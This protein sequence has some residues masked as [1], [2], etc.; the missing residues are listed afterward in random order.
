M[1]TR[2][3]CAD[4][5]FFIRK[6]SEAGSSAVACRDHRLL[7]GVLR[8]SHGCAIVDQ[9]AGARGGNWL[10]WAGDDPLLIV[11]AGLQVR[12]GAVRYEPLSWPP[13]SLTVAYLHITA[14]KDNQTEK[15]GATDC[16][17]ACGRLK[18]WSESSRYQSAEELSC[19][20]P[21]R[22]LSTDKEECSCESRT[23]AHQ[24]TGRQTTSSRYSY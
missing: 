15:K 5:S 20:V 4:S 13:L 23:P 12:V 18:S 16:M 21:K 9:D 2:A 17:R 1:F 11:T 7:D 19:Q 3:S 6:M 14:R 24:A 10:D 22:S 8:H